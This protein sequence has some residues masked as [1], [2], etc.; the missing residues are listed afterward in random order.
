MADAHELTMN[1]DRL[2]TTK[3]GAGRVSSNLGMQID[4][5][6]AW[7]RQEISQADRILRKG[8]NWYVYAGGAV[9]TVNA[10]SF[11]VITAHRVTEQELSAEQL[12]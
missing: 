7:C 1:L 9:I 12:Y 8:K 11:T 6:P 5:V 4:D 10:H 3:M 2:H